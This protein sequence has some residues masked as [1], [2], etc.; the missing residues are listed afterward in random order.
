MARGALA[1][2]IVL[3][4]M[5]LPAAA[6]D[7]TNDGWEGRRFNDKSTGA[8][9][10]CMVSKTFSSGSSLDFMIYLNR[11]IGSGPLDFIINAGSPSWQLDAGRTYPLRIWI[12]EQQLGSGGDEATFKNAAFA[13]IIY[14]SRTFRNLAHGHELKLRVNKKNAFYSLKGSAKALVWLKSCTEQ[15]LSGGALQDGRSPELWSATGNP[16]L[17][18]IRSILDDAGLIGYVMQ[19]RDDAGGLDLE[20]WRWG[21]GGGMKLIMYKVGRPFDA[22][23]ADSA[24]SIRR[25]CDEWSSAHKDGV[26][27]FGD[28]T[29]YGIS[30][31]KCVNDLAEVRYGVVAIDDNDGA[32]VIVQ[33]SDVRD[34][35]YEAHSRVFSVLH[36]MFD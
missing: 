20:E 12:D 15:G 1:L 17:R 14:V 9:D 11:D 30:S 26:Y 29:L 21:R 34:E 10:G 19:S 5:G 25:A 24:D 4:A 3:I 35:L 28:G 13:R 27:K 32:T 18:N 36:Y 23:L 7:F 6:V 8:F 33:Y 22:V 31:F 16:T 2:A